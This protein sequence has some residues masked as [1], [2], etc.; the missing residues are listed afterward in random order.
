LCYICDILDKNKLKDVILFNASSSEMYKG[1]TT[2]NV[3]DSNNIYMHHLH[4]YS[5]SKTLGHKYIHYYR[6]IHNFKFSNGVIFT[7]QSKEKGDDFLL[8]KIYKHIIDWNN[9]KT[10]PFLINGHLDSIKNIIHPY[11]VASAIKII[12]ESNTPGDL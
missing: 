11:D 2:C 10:T 7:S 6:D 4:P 8:S 9:G 1:L 12:I 5:I 3:N